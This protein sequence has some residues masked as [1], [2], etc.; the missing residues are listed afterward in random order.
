MFFNFSPIVRVG[1]WGVSAAVRSP[2]RSRPLVRQRWRC[3]YGRSRVGS[4]RSPVVRAASIAD[5]R[6]PTFYRQAVR[7]R[8]GSGV[9]HRSGAPTE[10]RLLAEHGGPNTVGRTRWAEHGGPNTVGRTRWAEHRAM[11]NHSANAVSDGRP[12]RM[13]GRLRGH[14][15]CRVSLHLRSLDGRNERL[16][17]TLSSSESRIRPAGL[18]V[19]S[20]RSVGGELN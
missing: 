6:S 2:G 3:R 15:D 8:E 11:R 1:G 5:L 10:Q 13:G 16:G 18:V 12:C 19:P 7:R 9:R 4:G 20:A 14:R 17:A